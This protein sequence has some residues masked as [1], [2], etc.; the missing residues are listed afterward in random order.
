MSGK[1]NGVAADS[2]RLREFQDRFARALIEPALSAGGDAALAQLVAQP[3]F[4]VYRNTVQKGCIDA[5]QANYPAVTR[6]VGEEWMRAAAAEFV[7]THPPESPML[8]EY[9]AQFAAFLDGFLP[10][11]DL[12]YLAGVAR[13]DRFWTEAHGARD[14]AVLEPGKLAALTHDELTRT[15]LQP[16][17][18][19]RWAWFDAQPIFTLWSRNRHGDGQN[20]D[21]E[22][23]GEGAL[24]VRPFDSVQAVGLARAD[25]AFLGVCAAGRTLDDAAL[26]ALAADPDADLAQSMA[27]LLSAGAFAYCEVDRR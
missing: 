10:A 19:A 5:L 13:L 18:S 17:A 3:G 14:E 15:R 9:G 12:P 11:A 27:R 16:H 22:W 1:M 23:R 26:A 20:G 24:I 8:L 7:R 25:V 2:G 21:I 6:L 4:A